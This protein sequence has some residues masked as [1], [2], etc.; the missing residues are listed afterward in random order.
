MGLAVPELWCRVAGSKLAELMSKG[1]VRLVMLSRV[2]EVSLRLLVGS[3]LWFK[4]SELKL[5]GGRLT[6]EVCNEAL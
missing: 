3:R 4:S 1:R 5:M 2:L 6:V